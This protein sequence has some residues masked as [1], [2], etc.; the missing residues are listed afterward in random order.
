M[1]DVEEKEKY[2]L[3]DYVKVVMFIS[4][5]RKIKNYG[6]DKPKVQKDGDWHTQ[7]ISEIIK[8]NCIKYQNQDGGNKMV[9]RIKYICPECKKLVHQFF[10]FKGVPLCSMCYRKKQTIIWF[11]SNLLKYDEPITEQVICTIGLT[12]KQFLLLRQKLNSLF[13]FKKLK[14]TSA[15]IR[16]LILKDIQQNE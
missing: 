6:K 11:P 7:N 3:K 2:M 13:P 4:I 14:S 15:Y 12:K 1:K 8:E 10:F 5:L 9:Q 16:E